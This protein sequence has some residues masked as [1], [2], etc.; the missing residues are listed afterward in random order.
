MQALG[1]PLKDVQGFVPKP[2]YYPGSVVQGV[3]LLKGEWLP[4]SVVFSSR[5]CLYLAPFL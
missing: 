4:Q 3:V 2:V 1:G 5:T